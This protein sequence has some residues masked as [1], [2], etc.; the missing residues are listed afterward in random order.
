MSVDSEFLGNLLDR[1][2]ATLVLFAR[3]WCNT[4][5]DIV[6]DAF[7]KLVTL[8]RPPDKIV[9]WLYRVVRNAAISTSR[10]TARRKRHET[11]SAETKQTW[12]V[13]SAED[14]LDAATA[15]EELRS[16]PLEQREAIVARLWGGLTFE[17]IGDVTGCGS[18]TAHRHYVEGAFYLERK[19]ERRCQLRDGM[20]TLRI[21]KARWRRW[22]LRPAESTETV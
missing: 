4:P 18:S 2:S 7:M 9:P 12:F 1:H 5:E 14:G 13:P 8:K 11:R 6:Q 15:V 16:L 19:V 20:A 21:S 22:C 17:E 3:Q 10:S